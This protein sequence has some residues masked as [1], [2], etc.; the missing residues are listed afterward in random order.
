MAAGA[1]ELSEPLQCRL[2]RHVVQA[3]DS[4]DDVVGAVG[5][6]E[7]QRVAL[8][9]GDVRSVGLDGPIRADARRGH[10]DGIDVV[11]ACCKCSR[12]ARC[13]SPRPARGHTTAGAGAADR[14]GRTDSSG[15]SSRPSGSSD[16]TRGAVHTDEVRTGSTSTSE[17]NRAE[18]NGL[19]LSPSVRTRPRTLG[20]WTHTSGVSLYLQGVCCCPVWVPLARETTVLR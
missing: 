4:G 7:A 8:D 19:C 11:C 20:F 2:E 13:R 3:G 16:K 6:L 14:R 18:S 10:V 17:S 9:P 5:E 1:H 15:H 12:E